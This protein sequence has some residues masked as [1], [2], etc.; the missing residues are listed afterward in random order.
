MKVVSNNG[1]VTKFDG[2]KESVSRLWEKWQHISTR[3]VY[4]RLCVYICCLEPMSGNELR[5][6]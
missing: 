1:S 3:N 2:F 6:F 5:F 4:L